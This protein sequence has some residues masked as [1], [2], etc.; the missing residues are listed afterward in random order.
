M[1]LFQGTHVHIVTGKADS[2]TSATG[3]VCRGY[4]YFHVCE[5]QAEVW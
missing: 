2:L 1:R 3:M 5:E 4:G